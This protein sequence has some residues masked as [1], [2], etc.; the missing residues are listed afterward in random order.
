MIPE[1]DFKNKDT[2]FYDLSSQE[3]FNVMLDNL[4]RNN[5]DLKERFKE[6]D[7]QAEKEI[8]RESFQKSKDVSAEVIQHKV[9]QKRTLRYSSSDDNEVYFI[10]LKLMSVLIFFYFGV[11]LSNLFLGSG[12]YFLV[13]MIFYY[14]MLY[15]DVPFSEKW[16]AWKELKTRRDMLE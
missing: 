7:E 11:W 15:I 13:L 9:F 3:Q 8:K 4:N 16:K 6:L 5:L 10:D 12:V 14:C 1:R 2:H